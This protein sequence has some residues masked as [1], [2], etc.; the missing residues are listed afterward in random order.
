MM[1]MEK[2]VLS[3]KSDINKLYALALQILI[4]VY[5]TELI[6]QQTHPL[7]KHKMLQSLFKLYF[8]L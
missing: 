1:A 4:F 8:L 5:I 2:F 7:L 3:L 6:F